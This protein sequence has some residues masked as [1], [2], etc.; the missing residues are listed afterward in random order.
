MISR[1][2][3]VSVCIP[4]YNRSTMLREAV[5]SVL[6]QTFQDFELVIS[7]NA[8]DDETTEVARSFNDK[9]IRH[10]RNAHNIG[11]RKNWNR[12]LTVASGEYMTILPDD[13]LM[14]PDNLE[15][16]VDVLAN[17]PEVGLV[18]SKYHLIDSEGTIIEE[19]TNWGHGPNRTKDAIEKGRDVLISML[20]TYNMI[21]APTVLMR[22]AVYERLGGFTDRLS[23]AFD[24]EYWMRVAAHYDVAFLVRPLIKWRIHS[25]SLS[26]E[27]LAVKRLIIKNH[28][29]AIPDGGNIKK[30]VGKERI[31]RIIRRAEEMLGDDGP[32]R[33]VRNFLL[34]MCAVF[35]DIAFAKRTWKVFL[36]TILS[37]P[38]I[39]L[40][41]R[42]L[43]V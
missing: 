15:A 21:N 9:R 2:P 25:G 22:K 12:C 41:K 18:H 1:R 5:E 31:S 30:Q 13:D 14:M 37:R 35:P 20:L 38:S 11:H 42:V 39:E 43:P 24:W 32:D 36:K 40:L 3:K 4:T 19:D 10:V 27:E 8:S 16:K 6:L 33:E 23:L 34:E 7:D 28:L 29:Q 17:N 26:R